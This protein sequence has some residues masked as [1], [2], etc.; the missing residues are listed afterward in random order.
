MLVARTEDVS[1]LTDQ[2]T[3][4]EGTRSLSAS[5]SGPK[6]DVPYIDVP[7]GQWLVFMQLVYR[8]L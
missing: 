6:V 4:E 1:R 8:G 2:E 7:K 3:G 5:P